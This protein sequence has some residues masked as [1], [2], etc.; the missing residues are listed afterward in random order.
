MALTWLIQ[1]SLRS[2]AM[3]VWWKLGYTQQEQLQLQQQQQLSRHAG[4]STTS[5]DLQWPCSLQVNNNMHTKRKEPDKVRPAKSR[6]MASA[7]LPSRHLA[8]SLYR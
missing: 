7:L 8:I 3:R 6:P 2:R 5:F 1:V 4:A